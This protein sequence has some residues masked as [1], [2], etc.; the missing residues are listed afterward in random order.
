M[1]LGQENSLRDSFG[2]FNSNLVLNSL[3]II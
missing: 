1:T 2:E 3:V